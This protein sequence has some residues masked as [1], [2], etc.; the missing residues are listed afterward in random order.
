MS[1]N[2]ST[3]LDQIDWERVISIVHKSEHKTEV[4]I[5]DQNRSYTESPLS[6]SL[7][8]YASDLK[9]H[10]GKLD[11]RRLTPI[12]A[13]SIHTSECEQILNCSACK[14]S[15]MIFRKFDFIW[16]G[17]RLNALSPVKWIISDAMSRTNAVSIQHNPLK[18][19]I[20][21][22]PIID[23]LNE[24]SDSMSNAAKYPC[25]FFQLNGNLFWW[26]KS[27]KTKDKSLDNCCHVTMLHHRF[28]LRCQLTL[29]EMVKYTD[30]RP[31]RTY[32]IHKSWTNMVER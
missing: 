3:S 10:A 28:I 23:R 21:S 13:S 19:H 22:A 25:Q 29:L 2:S 31:N 16:L 1:L 32:I 24:T 11:P 17:L 18:K 7:E 8:N 20:G 30:H 27:T 26:W 9:F 12:E 14:I 15:R 5:W 6:L 4:S